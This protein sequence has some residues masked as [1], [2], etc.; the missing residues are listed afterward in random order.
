MLRAS[1]GIETEVLVIDNNSS[2]HS[3]ERLQPRFPGVVFVANENIG[4]ARACNQGWRMSKDEYILFLIPIPLFRKTALA[5]A[6]VLWPRIPEAG[7]PGHPYAGWV[8]VSCR[9]EAGFPFADDL[10]V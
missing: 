5:N 6:S 8:A 4:F 7:A 9:I 1:A 2:D 10:V 3:I